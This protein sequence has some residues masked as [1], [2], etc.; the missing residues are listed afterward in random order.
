MEQVRLDPCRELL[1]DASA[2]VRGAAVWAMSRLVDKREF[3]RMANQATDA[4][5]DVMAEWRSARTS[6]GPKR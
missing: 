2:L 5:E 6:Y 3:A 4:D 1:A